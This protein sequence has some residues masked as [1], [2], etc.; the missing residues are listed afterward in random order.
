MHRIRRSLV[1]AAALAC[2]PTTTPPPALATVTSGPALAEA[3]L[4]HDVCERSHGR[5]PAPK[6]AP[7]GE[8][9]VLAD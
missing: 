7:A 2:G 8:F 3:D 1:L 6:A 9:A 4:A 5:E